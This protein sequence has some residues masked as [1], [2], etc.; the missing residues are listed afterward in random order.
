MKTLE[1]QLSSYAAYHRDPRNIATH[2]IGIPLIVMA[3]TVLL[4]RPS[5]PFMGLA[6]SPAL[7]AEI[8][9]AHV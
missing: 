3:I 2:F 4:S 9:R 5:L 7:I 8:G 6:I 1:D